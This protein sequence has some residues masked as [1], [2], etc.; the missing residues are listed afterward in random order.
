MQIYALYERS[1]KIKIFLI[2][3]CTIEVVAMVVLIAITMSHLESLPILSTNTGCAY[4]GLLSVSSLFWIPGL[5][6]EPILFALVAYKAW[7]NRENEPSVP[8]ITRMARESLIYFAVIF[9]EL[10][11]ST[12][13]WARAP[14]YIN[15]FNPWSAA[16]PS[17]LGCRLMLS[18]REA[19]YQRSDPRSYI[20]EMF[21]A[22]TSP[23]RPSCFNPRRSPWEYSHIEFGETM[24]IIEHTMFSD[25][26]RTGSETYS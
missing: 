20:M 11:L 5:V 9:V 13:V 18:M 8:L 6:Y 19:V 12:V 1:R 4:Q 17:L 16:L 21:S 26:E 22:P 2:V 24:D 10:L 15:L 23:S 7:G 25:A 3:A 14:E